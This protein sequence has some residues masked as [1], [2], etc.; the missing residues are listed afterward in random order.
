MRSLSR[1][2]LALVFL[3]V[4]SFVLFTPKPTLAA[5]DCTCTG[6]MEY[7]Y[8]V[9]AVTQG[10][11]QLSFEK[12]CTDVRGT[13]A[14]GA[15]GE[16]STCKN[17]KFTSTFNTATCSDVGSSEIRDV[18]NLPIN[19]WA[20]FTSSIICGQKAPDSTLSNNRTTSSTSSSVIG[21]APPSIS[22]VCTGQNCTKSEVGPF[23]QG[24]TSQCYNSG[25]CQ[26]DD[27]MA[28]FANVGNWIAA[29]IAVIVFLFY[30]YG[31]FNLLLAGGSSER[32][33][34]GKTI[35]KTAT[36]GLIIVFSAYMLITT[37]S[38][39]LLPS[40]TFAEITGPTWVKNICK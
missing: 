20:A 6:S 19:T 7:N 40:K 33:Q 12:T 9:A 35:M 8:A 21:T 16:N 5:V 27:I 17:I 31:G 10:P 36:V 23:M 22:K 39:T 30:V 3:L 4:S 28:V 13:Y 24:I 14:L 29:I 34:K 1:V 18:L 32:V 2:F 37:L 25:Q 38:C 11:F 26:L 15:I